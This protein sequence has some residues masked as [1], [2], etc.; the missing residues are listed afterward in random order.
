MVR[1]ELV[2]VDRIKTVVPASDS[3][4]RCSWLPINF[5]RT[6]SPPTTST[7]PWTREKRYGLATPFNN[8]LPEAAFLFGEDISDYLNECSKSWTELYGLEAELNDVAGR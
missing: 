3:R 7:S 4:L 6:W 8:F 2:Q 5:A 1:P